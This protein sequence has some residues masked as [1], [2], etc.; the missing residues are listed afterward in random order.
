ML[1]E[2]LRGPAESTGHAARL[3]RLI[4]A[5]PRLQQLIYPVMCFGHPPAQWQDWD[6]EKDGQ[7]CESY[8]KYH[9]LYDELRA[10]MVFLAR[11]RRG[12]GVDNEGFENKIDAEHDDSKLPLD[13][14][15]LDSAPNKAQSSF[16]GEKARGG[17][18]SHEEKS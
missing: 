7:F 9:V 17:H 8:I 3:E 16:V 18:R 15:A 1:N 2:I 14:E 5:Y 6:V 12:V 13:H 4:R 10:H 11:Q